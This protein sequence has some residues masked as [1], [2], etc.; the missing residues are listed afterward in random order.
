MLLNKLQKLAVAL[1][2]KYQ[3]D[4]EPMVVASG[5]GRI[6]EAIIK[7]ANDAD[8]PVHED[9][10]LAEL[11]YQVEVGSSI[12]DEL[13]DVVAQLIAM[14]YKMDKKMDQPV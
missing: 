4:K 1:K 10:H 9:N 14:I 6:A 2:Y 3:E 11:L 7:K 12:P 8:V 5:R 13:Y